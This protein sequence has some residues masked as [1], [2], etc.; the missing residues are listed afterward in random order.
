[1]K[2]LF[3]LFLLFMTKSTIASTLPI[4]LEAGLT[5]RYK[6]EINTFWQQGNFNSFE[7]VDAIDI[8]Y[9]EFVSPHRDKCIVIVSGRS[10]GYLKYKELSYDLA[11]QGYNL[12]LI[13]HRGQGL[14]GKMLSNR[15]KGF[16]ASFDHYSDDLHTFVETIVKPQCQQDIF[17]LA[18]SMGGAISA[19]YMQRYQTPITAAVL[20]SP[21]IAINSGGIPQWLAK[22]II[23][24][25][26]SLSKLIS[27][28]AWYFL[29]QGDYK[30]IAFEQNKLMQSGTRYQIFTDLYQQES[31]LQLGGV[32]YHWL[33]E[34]LNANKAL[35]NDISK[36]ETPVTIIQAG[37]DTVVDNQAQHDFCQALHQQHTHS[38][39]SGKPIVI[40]NALHE[41]FF[42]SDQYRLQGIEAT[43]NWFN[44]HTGLPQN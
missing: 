15:H 11:N 22:L 14:S 8:R 34:A 18:H 41:I 35:F 30:T 1:M 6:N 19:R 33:Q 3:R 16:V 28:E 32:T 23:S 37:A 21:M 43:L 26:D 2:L 39:P 10:E 20:A 17:L 27:D 4:S 5:E 44:R 9:A 38:C 40:D 29:G 24:T 31:K 36:L 25:G 7:G 13:D 42:E 12:F